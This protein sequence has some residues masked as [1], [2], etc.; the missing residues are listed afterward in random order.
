MRNGLLPMKE[1]NPI[2]KSNNLNFE[3]NNR[4]KKIISASGLLFE[5]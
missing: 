5:D 3:K 4:H 1:F 2:T